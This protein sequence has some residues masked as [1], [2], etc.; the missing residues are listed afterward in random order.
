MNKAINLTYSIRV[1][2][3]LSG[4]LSQFFFS[5][6]AVA[7]KSTN[8]LE[9]EIYHIILTL[10]N[11]CSSYD[12]NLEIDSCLAV[13]IEKAENDIVQILYTETDILKRERLKAMVYV[14]SEASRKNN[15]AMRIHFFPF[16]P[17]FTKQ[18]YPIQSPKKLTELLTQ[19]LIEKGE[20]ERIAIPQEEIAK[21]AR[22]M[23]QDASE[24]LIFSMIGSL[25]LEF[26]L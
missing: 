5:Y 18:L 2:C 23:S 15:V 14:T 6:Q 1:I 8:Y 10:D 4:I 17:S 3:I 26:R 13:L 20:E 12:D 21:Q 24:V 25:L 19:V 11:A 7:Q 9:S 22:E 16:S